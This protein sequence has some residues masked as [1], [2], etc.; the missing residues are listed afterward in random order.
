MSIDGFSQ[1]GKTYTT[2]DGADFVKK[3]YVEY[4]DI[5]NRETC[6]TLRDKMI[7]K[8]Y[9]PLLNKKELNAG[10]DFII[11]AQDANAESAETVTVTSLGNRWYIASYMIIYNKKRVEIP[12]HLT[13]VN[14]Q[15][16]IDN[17]ITAGETVPQTKQVNKRGVVNTDKDI[18]ALVKFY[19]KYLKQ[20]SNDESSKCRL[21]YMTSNYCSF[22][23]KT[24]I[25]ENKRNVL[26]CGVSQ[27]SKSASSTVKV[28]SLKDWHY[29]VTFISNGKKYQ[30][31][32]H[33]TKSK[34]KLAIDNL[35]I[36]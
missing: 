35:F 29:L 33:I 25:S 20:M 23:N 31:K 8:S 21:K 17:I 34:G 26:V 18:A 11:R 5:L 6:E 27:T 1:N 36:I 4:L 24:S 13:T 32:V 7:S 19:K 2:K 28:S 3:F 30:R 16:C 9:S 10:F 15:P 14:G 12:V 22:I